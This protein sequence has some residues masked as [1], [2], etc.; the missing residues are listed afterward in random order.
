VKFAERI[1]GLIEFFT[2]K[3]SRPPGAEIS[4]KDCDD[5]ANIAKPIAMHGG[6]QNITVINASGSAQVVLQTNAREAARALEGASREKARLTRAQAGV[7]TRKGV[8]LVWTQTARDAVKTK[9][10]TSPDKGI[11][12][13]IDPKSHAVLFTDETAHIKREM[14]Q[15]EENPYKKVYFV[16]AEVSRAADDKITAYR[17]VGYHGKDDLAET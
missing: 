12:Y 15:D 2:G 6:V 13:E 5:I 3:A 10:A 4:I 1:K 11:I 14:M 9:G 8:S 7:D 16:D 17:I